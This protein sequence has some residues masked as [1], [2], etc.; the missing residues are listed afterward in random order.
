MRQL[1]RVRDAMIVSRRK[2]RGKP[3]ES[4]DRLKS[5]VERHI[6]N[7]EATLYEPLRLKF[8]RGGPIDTMTRE[9]R[10]IRQSLGRL[11]SALDA[12]SAGRTRIADLQSSLNSLQKEIGEHIEKEEKVLFWL[13]DL[14]L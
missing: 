13:A 12:Y 7:E 3:A 14:K 1:D 6:L 2:S 8:G 5:M 4:I 11:L 9:H 10:S